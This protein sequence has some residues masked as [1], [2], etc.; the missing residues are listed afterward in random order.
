MLAARRAQA[1]LVELDPKY[2]DV[3]VHR[4]QES[5]GGTA[6]LDGDGGSFGALAGQR[7]GS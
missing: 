6:T 2:C 7:R 3:I 4:W 1:K 5:I